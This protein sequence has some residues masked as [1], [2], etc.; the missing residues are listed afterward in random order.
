MIFVVTRPLEN[1]N[2]S[3]TDRN[4][5]FLP[6]FRYQDVNPVKFIYDHTTIFILTSQRASKWVIKNKLS[7]ENTYYCVGEKT[8]ELLKKSNF[9]NVFF[10]PLSAAQSL[11]TFI[12]KRHCNGQSYIYLAGDV[13][14]KTIHKILEKAG[15][16]CAK[17]IVYKT[18]AIIHPLKKILSLTTPYGFLFYSIQSY[19]FFIENL[20]QENMIKICANSCAIFVLPHR[21]KGFVFNVINDIK[22]GKYDV[23]HDT[24]DFLRSVEKNIL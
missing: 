19:K 17:H 16:P 1:C 5:L 3:L 14:K 9:K 21:T 10:S 24:Q 12:E 7:P 4:F 23:F 20:R 8:A 18:E 15:L 22:W 2:D 11:I 13:I 6:A